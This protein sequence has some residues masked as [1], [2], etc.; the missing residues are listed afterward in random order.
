MLFESLP[1]D[2]ASFSGQDK[3]FTERNLISHL[4]ALRA[5]SDGQPVDEH[6]F[7]WSTTEHHKQENGSSKLRCM[8]M[9]AVGYKSAIVVV[10][11][12]SATNKSAKRPV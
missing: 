5:E 2:H 8:L 1:T 9:A 3:R 6:D 10:D 7:C 12:E 4:P 11:V